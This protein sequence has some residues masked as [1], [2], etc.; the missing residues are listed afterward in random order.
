[1][2]LLSGSD[3]TEVY[4][5]QIA[6]GVRDNVAKAH[7]R[8]SYRFR[9]TEAKMD[10]RYR[11]FTPPPSAGIRVKCNQVYFITDYIDE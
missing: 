10:W 8:I 9:D 3:A 2:L 1:M 7:C 4:T 5:R 11:I 6:I